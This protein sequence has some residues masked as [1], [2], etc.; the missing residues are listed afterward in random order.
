MLCS[1]TQNV[2]VALENHFVNNESIKAF[3]ILNPSNML[4]RQV[5]LASWD[6]LELG[7][8]CGHYGQDLE[9]YRKEFEAL[10]NPSSKP[11]T[12]KWEFFAFTLQATTKWLDKGFGD[13]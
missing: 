9:L 13:L 5:G 1:Y 8:L 3:K 2:R 6:F 10:N 12:T 4:T 7:I 11:S